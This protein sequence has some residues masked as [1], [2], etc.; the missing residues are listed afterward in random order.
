M[1]SNL[2]ISAGPRGPPT[3]V[4]VYTSGM[5][6]PR[7]ALLLPI[8]A[9]APAFAQG[10]LSPLEVNKKVV[11]DFYRLVF[12]PRNTDLIDQ[13]VGDTFIEHNPRYESGK[14]N[15]AKL[16][17]SLPPGKEDIGDKLQDP[18]EL[19]V[20]EGD[21]VT[22]VFKRKTPDPKD[23]SKPYERYAFDTLRIQDKQS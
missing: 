21:L 10:Y 6:L 17:K 4:E 11:F 15:L 18:P 23:K 22:Y 5:K 14:A 19:I 3:L 16:I 1:I 20:A 13:F 7:I 2:L 8:L 12:E 9:A